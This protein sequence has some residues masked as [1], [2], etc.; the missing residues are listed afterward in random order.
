MNLLKYGA[1][2][3]YAGERI[4]PPVASDLTGL[5]K[6]GDNELRVEVRT[7]LAAK[8]A[9]NDRW[10]RFIWTRGDCG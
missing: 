2:D 5:T 6:T 1:I 8:S 4:C 10:S 7:T 9:C 3:K